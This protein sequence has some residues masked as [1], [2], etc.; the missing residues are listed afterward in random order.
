MGKIFGNE[1]IPRKIGWKSEVFFSFFFQ[2]IV[3]FFAKRLQLKSCRLLALILSL[4]L[5]ILIDL[6]GA[7]H[8]K[9]ANQLF[10]YLT[11]QRYFRDMTF[12]LFIYFMFF[13]FWK[14]IDNFVK[15]PSCRHAH[16]IN[17]GKGA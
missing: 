9:A 1:K 4:Q 15:A 13:F 8:P 7:W 14:P 17:R 16:K 6:L 12:Y 10:L 5:E 2:R 3:C 11:K